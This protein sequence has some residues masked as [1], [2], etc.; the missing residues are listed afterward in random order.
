M[1]AQTYLHIPTPCHEDWGKMSPNQQG[2]H[3]ESCCKTVVDFQLMTDQQVL[4]FFAKE[5]GNTCGR[6]STDQ[7]NRALE[8]TKIEKKKGWQW[9]MASIASFSFFI[10]KGSAQPMQGKVAVCKPPST[11]TKQPTVKQTKTVK[12]KSAKGTV[13]KIVYENPTIVGDVVAMPIEAIHEPD[14]IENKL[15]KID[16]AIAVNKGAKLIGAVTDENGKPIAG[17]MVV[18]FTAH[19]KIT[20]QTNEEGEYIFNNPMQ[21]NEEVELAFSSLGYEEKRVPVTF[22][23]SKLE[24]HIQLKEKPKQLD[25]VVV[26]GYQ[27]YQTVKRIDYMG[28]VSSVSIKQI[29]KVDTVSTILRK[30]FKAEGFSIFPNPA[31]KGKA[32]N[33]VINEAGEFSIQLLDNSSKLLHVEN[34][35]VINKKE[36]K[37]FNIP[38]AIASGMYYIR[39]VNDK[40]KKQYVGKLLVQ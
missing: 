29:K 12:T 38:S 40:T 37:L 1:K 31:S 14:A 25:E 2:R 6:F 15:L 13:S 33:L 36:I 20:H 22:D 30:V 9:L 28:A 18:A 32:V 8:E 26:V 24:L 35:T 17:A 19:G 39:L 21:L 11:T 10:S 34:A 23:E 27:T 4:N 3:C 7:L 5:N 16:T